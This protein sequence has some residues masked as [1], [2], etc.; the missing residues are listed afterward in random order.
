MHAVNNIDFTTDIQEKPNTSYA[1]NDRDNL[2]F[3]PIIE[4]TRTY[5]IKLPL[6]Q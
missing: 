1:F 2:D 6:G 4:A 5:V 3:R